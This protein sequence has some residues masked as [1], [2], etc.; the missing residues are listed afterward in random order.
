[1]RKFF[2]TLI[3]SFFYVNSSFGSWKEVS[4]DQ[5]S[6]Q[7]LNDNF[8]PTY[9]SKIF[10]QGV[11]GNYMLLEN[12]STGESIEIQHDYFMDHNAIW[13]N[14]WANQ[15]LKK[16]KLRN[17]LESYGLGRVEHID[18]KSTM[19]KSGIYYKNYTTSQGAG[20][21]LA[22]QKQNHIWSIGYYIAGG[23]GDVDKSTIDYL[24]KPIK[25][26]GIKKGEQAFYKQNTPSNSS[27][28]NDFI[29]FCKNSTISELSADVALLC[30]E[31]LK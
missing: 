20:F 31:K 24:Y 30:L 26:R 6:I 15:Y 10:D 14:D 29:T 18:N 16:D 5:L 22:T 13:S 8:T 4:C 19:Y 25:L 7:Y 21:A 1:M 11:H 3:I 23:S 12:Y 2:L 9:C 17:L 28:D 27:D